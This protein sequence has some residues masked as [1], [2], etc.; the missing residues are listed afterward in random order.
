[1]WVGQTAIDKFLKLPIVSGP[2]S[3]KTETYLPA[4]TQHMCTSFKSKYTLMKAV[5]K[6]PHGTE[7]KLKRINVEG[8]IL[9]NGQ[10]EHK[11]LELW[12]RNPVDCIRELMANT[13][14]NGVVSY[15]PER[16]FEDVEGKVRQYEAGLFDPRQ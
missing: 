15:T 7:W 3:V 11:E 6:L 8:N 2:A 13:E 1:L 12:L 16:V 14:F 4:Q 5:D 10:C 9:T